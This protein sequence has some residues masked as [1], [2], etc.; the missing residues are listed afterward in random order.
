MQ[1]MLRLAKMFALCN[2]HCPLSLSG[3]KNKL[4]KNLKLSFQ[5]TYSLPS[6]LCHHNKVTDA[7]GPLLGWPYFDDRTPGHLSR[8]LDTQRSLIISIY[9][10][11]VFTSKKKIT[12]KRTGCENRTC[13]GKAGCLVILLLFWTAVQ[14]RP[15]PTRQQIG[16][17]GYMWHVSMNNIYKKQ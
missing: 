13:P 5:W 11:Y 2:F 6:F 10:K 8:Q 15:W 16:S 14:K 4:K 9:L 7:H 17:F 3:V 1:G 12:S